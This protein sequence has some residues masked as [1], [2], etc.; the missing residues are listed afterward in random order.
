[1]VS[2]HPLF[3][4]RSTG[5][6]ASGV[7]LSPWDQHEPPRLIED[8]T[9]QPPYTPLLRAPEK[10]HPWE[11]HNCLPP[12][13]EPSGSSGQLHSQAAIRRMEPT[14]VATDSVWPVTMYKLGQQSRVLSLGSATPPVLQQLARRGTSST[15]SNA[16]NATNNTW[17]KQRTRLNRQWNIS[18][19]RI[20]KPVAAHFT[21]PE[22]SLR[23]L[24][25][26]VIEQMRSQ[27][28]EGELLHSQTAMPTPCRHEHWRVAGSSRSCDDAMETIRV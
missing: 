5:P 15:S 13:G 3:K 12:T 2:H 7:M 14:P 11:P 26:R 1:M 6:L 27:D 24:S 16:G 28:E 19:R 18:H 9:G 23:D 17:G 20:E 22:H 8:Y 21:S 25:I 4:G 10:C